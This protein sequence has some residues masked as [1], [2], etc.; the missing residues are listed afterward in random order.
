MAMLRPSWCAS[1]LRQDWGRSYIIRRPTASRKAKWI[2]TGTCF[3]GRCP[4]A[5]RAS[6]PAQRAWT[7]TRFT[8]IETAPESRERLC[9]NFLVADGAA[10]LSPEL[11]AGPAAAVAAVASAAAAS[12]ATFAVESLRPAAGLVEAVAQLRP[13][14]DPHYRRRCHCRRPLPLHSPRVQVPARPDL[15][16]GSQVEECPPQPGSARFPEDRSWRP[17]RHA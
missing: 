15:P 1:Y 13:P 10:C 7:L 5:I 17:A 9:L 6:R 12:P 11:E 3:R 16:P 4:N 2:A 8:E 14:V